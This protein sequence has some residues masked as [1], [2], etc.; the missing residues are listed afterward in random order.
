MQHD[1]L[2]NIELHTFTNPTRIDNP[3]LPLHPGKQLVFEGYTTEED[4]AGIP[5]EI[6][7][8]VLFTATDLTKVIAGIR[9]F[10][11]YELDYSA[12]ELVER[13]LVF[14][15]QDD[16]GTVWHLG[17]HP[18]AF[19]DGVLVE[20]PTWL[21]G[22]EKA[23][24]GIMMQAHPTVGTPS[25]SQGLGPAVDYTDRAQIEEMGSTV[26]VTYGTF[27][28]TLLIAESSE[29]EED[30]FQLKTYA[31]GVG[32]IRVGFRGA[33]AT[34]ETLE[35]ID[36][37]ELDVAE[38]AEVRDVVLALEAHA[39]TISKNSSLAYRTTT[40]MERVPPLL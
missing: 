29:A 14:F 7:H 35:L 24:A 34:H 20:F 18:E 31:R 21:H 10:V 15:A 40:E 8:Q 28:D 33:D 22:L 16:D 36:V 37:I 19:E 2:E 1:L 38:L 23:R 26:V 11:S 30:A 12:G 9:C 17:Q 4:D 3:W 5:Q 32:N 27:N 25:Y 6:P 39:Y 13:E